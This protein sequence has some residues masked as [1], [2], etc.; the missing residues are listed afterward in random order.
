MCLCAESETTDGLIVLLFCDVHI[1][2]HVCATLNLLQ[3]L[4][5][6]CGCRAVQTNSARDITGTAAYVAIATI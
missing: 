4:C 3:C 5:V 2:I 6:I 1:D